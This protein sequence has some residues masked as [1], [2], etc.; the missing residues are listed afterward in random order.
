VIELQHTQIGFAAINAGMT[1]KILPNPAPIART[2]ARGV[3]HAPLIMKFLVSAIVS[4]TIFVLTFSAAARE[5]N[6]MLG[7]PFEWKQLMTNSTPLHGKN[8]TTRKCQ[9]YCT[10]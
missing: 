6:A 3:C 8:R 5:A 1:A 10:R 2:V 4:L 7:E 9:L